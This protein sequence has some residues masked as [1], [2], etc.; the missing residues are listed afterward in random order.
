MSNK[1]R[2]NERM[3]RIATPKDTMLTDFL[4]AKTVEEKRRV[5]ETF[6]PH[7]FALTPSRKE[8]DETEAQVV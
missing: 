1:T 8:Q 6:A 3:K 4:R 5:I 2:K 7:Y